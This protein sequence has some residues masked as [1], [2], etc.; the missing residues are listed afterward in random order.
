[1]SFYQELGSWSAPRGP[2]LSSSPTVGFQGP[3]TD[4]LPTGH[5]RQTIVA[6]LRHCG[7]PFAEKTYLNIR[8]VARAHKDIDF[9][10]VSHSDEAS[11]KRWLQSL[12]QAG[13]GP[14]NLSM[15]VDPELELY[16]KWGLGPSSYAHVL[17]FSSLQEVW[18][19]AKE[20]GIS[21]RPTES[22]RR[23][24]T[25]NFWTIDTDGIV[26]WGRSARSADDVPDLEEA[27]EALEGNTGSEARFHA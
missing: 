8:E 17:N 10:A 7:C 5:G 4:R 14:A 22:G 1:M 15:I 19:L 6:F 23:W 3:S 20:E 12:P 21:N 9:T 11:T 18:R 25:S 2:S 13:S 27:V 16:A 24:Q 26:R